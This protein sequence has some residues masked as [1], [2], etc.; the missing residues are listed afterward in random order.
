MQRRCVAPYLKCTLTNHQGPMGWARAPGFFQHYW[1]IVGHDVTMFCRRFVETTKLPTKANDTFIV[2]IP[3]KANPDSMKDLRPIALCNVLYKVAAKVIANRMKTVLDGL[4]SQAQSAFIPGRLITDNIM[5]A[6]EAHH[7]LKR[8]T[9]GKEGVVALK[10][11][12]SKAY[13]RVEWQFL[14]GVML[15]MGFATKWVDLIMET[16][17]SVKYHVLHEQRQFGPISPGRGLRQGDPLSPYLFLFVAEGLS[18]LIDRQMRLN[19]LRGAFVARGAPSISHLLFADDCFLFFRANEPESLRMKWVLDVYSKASGQQINFDKSMICFSANVQPAVRNYLVTMLGV[20]EGDTSGKYL[21]LPSLI[22]R[23]KK[24]ILG[25]LKGKILNKVRSWN[26]RF[27]SRAGR[28]V[29]LKN[30]VQAMPSYAMMVFLLPLG[31]CKEIEILMNEYWWTGSIGNGKGIRWRN[32]ASLCTP[33]SGGGMGFRRMHEMNL[34][35]LG[36]QAWRLL[37]M[38]HSLMARVYKARY[39]PKTSYFDASLGSNPS[40]IWRSLM[41]VQTIS[42]EGCHK[43]IGNGNTTIIGTDPWLPDVQNPHATTILHENIA[44]APVSSL[45]SMHGSEWDYEC[46]RD[47]FNTC[48]AQLILNIPLSVRMPPDSWIW[49]VEPKEKYSVKSCYRMLL[50][51]YTDSRPWTKLWKLQV[52]PK[53]KVFCWQLSSGYLPT[54][55]ALNTKHMVCSVM[56][57]LCQQQVESAYHLFAGCCE[58]KRLW[59]NVGLLISYIGNDDLSQWFF[60]NISIMAG[61]NLCKFVML[62]WGLWFNRNEFV[63]KNIP[64]VVGKVIQTSMALWLGWKSVHEDELLAIHT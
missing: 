33:K 7:F 39:F 3:K 29:L 18:A 10:V 17:S 63:L 5:L 8:K 51:E 55:D 23:K 28:E 32:W 64:Y 48:D 47:I 53:V 54:R 35:L 16:V 56:C 20:R 58:V 41:E 24:E 45:M 44:Q 49:A 2:L 60:R 11:D 36:K 46:V 26:A 52:P 31:L 21:G 12:M 19:L 22:G 40:Y 59:D 1:D 13:D 42:R 38:P 43:C 61:N 57:F 34:A 9:Q 25:F 37:T 27:L 4:I 62:L 14:K 50:G 6:Y 30:V 15:K